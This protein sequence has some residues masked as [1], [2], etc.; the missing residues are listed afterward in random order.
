MRL[1]SLANYFTMA[2]KSECRRWTMQLD[3]WSFNGGMQSLFGPMNFAEAHLSSIPDD[4]VS[5]A[6]SHDSRRHQIIYELPDILLPLGA[7]NDCNRTI[8]LPKPDA[9]DTQA[10]CVA[11]KKGKEKHKCNGYKMA[12]AVEGLIEYAEAAVPICTH[13]TVSLARD[14]T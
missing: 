8:D 7:D 4:K 13:F 6:I 9:D 3:S 5:C 12:H 11:Y 2:M 14:Y 10:T 1:R